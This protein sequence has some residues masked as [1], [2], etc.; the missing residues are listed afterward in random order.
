MRSVFLI[1]DGLG[2]RN[3]ALGG[4]L[5]RVAAKGPVDVLHRL[6][7]RA[8]ARVSGGDSPV[9]WTPA[10]AGSP[11]AVEATLQVALKY[12]HMRATG[13]RA[14]RWKVTRP[15]TGR[16]RGRL[17]K[18]T[19]RAVSSL[20]ASPA[21]IERLNQWH[22][23]HA[24]HS[25]LVEQYR[26]LFGELQPDVVVCSNHVMETFVA[27]VLAARSLRIPTVAF[28]ASW[29]SLTTNERI[30]APFQHYLVWSS[31]MKQELLSYYPDVEPANVHVVGTPQLDLYGRQEL[32]WSRR[33]FFE[34]IGADPDR[35]LI[36][37]SGAAVRLNID[38]PLH[39]R[40]LLELIR[41][42]RIGNRPQVVFRRNPWDWTRRHTDLQREYPELIAAEP[43]WE[44][45]PSANWTDMIPLPDDVR[46]MANLA[47]HSDLNVNVASTMSIEFA[48]CDRPVVNIAFDVSQPPPFGIPLWEHFYQWE[49]Y[50]PVWQLG[51]VRV[52]RSMDGLADHIN[53]Y[54]DNPTLD[55]EARRRLV[56]LELGAK[57]GTSAGRVADTLESIA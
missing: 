8:V 5:D 23:H 38:E 36:C 54:L 28:L 55:R 24:A 41:S 31:G 9:R 16:W 14:H 12:A 50:R 21:R 11:D 13:T 45:A 3:L 56:D 39:L 53:A 44:A 52:A 17:F 26:R 10:P 37:Y 32:L 51:A 1:F 6:P 46:L 29:D 43:F 7:D 15:V 48:I 35:P 49:H 19:L 20:A 2:Y 40:G 27:P 30:L 22:L 34:R 42:G 47:H 25:G 57:S 4:S 33:E 18:R